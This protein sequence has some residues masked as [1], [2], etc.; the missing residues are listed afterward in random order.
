MDNVEDGIY[1]DENN[2]RMVTNF[3][4]QMS[5]LADE[6]LAQGEDEKALDVLEQILVK[7]PEENVPI[8][9]VLVSVQSSLMELAASGEIPGFQKKELSEERR[10]RA[11]ELAISLTE[12]LFDI[13]EDKLRYYHSLDYRRFQSVSQESR[14]SK[15]VANMMIQTA[16]TYLKEDSLSSNLEKRMGLLEAEMAEAERRFATMGSFEF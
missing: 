9:R 7:M 10:A 8:N 15:Q 2:R 6:L 11:R 16:A 5:I 3:R 14:I 13:Q 12:R 1:M 4:L